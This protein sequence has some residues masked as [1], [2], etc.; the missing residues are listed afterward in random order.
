MKTV[1]LALSGAAARGYAHIGVIRELINNGFKINAIAG[2]S[3][4]AVVGAMFAA[5]KLDE[6]EKWVKNLYQHDI[7]NLLGFSRKGGLI[8]TDKLFSVLGEMIGQNTLIEDLP[9]KFCA[10]CVDIISKREVW[11]QEGNLLFA[12]RASSAIPSI[13]YPVEANGHLYVDGGILNNLPVG[14]LKNAQS[15]YVI[16]VDINSNTKTKYDVYI[17]Q[18]EEERQN[19]LFA[20]FQ[21]ISKKIGKNSQNRYSMFDVA[22]ISLDIM[23]N[24]LKSYRLAENKVDILIEIPQSICKVYDFHKAQQLI[25]IGQIATKKALDYYQ[26][27][28]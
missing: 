22:A 14:A 5:N 19:S 21:K 11:F 10:V 24:L 18:D 23:Q 8:N 17:T 1:S 15:D 27:K 28:Q 25:Q 12:I 16:A 20:Q 3:M 13:F 4:G 6:Y 7:I 2:T 26:Q 9:I